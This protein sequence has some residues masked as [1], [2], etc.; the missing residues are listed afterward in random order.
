M[1]ALLSSLGYPITTLARESYDP[2]FQELVYERLRT[3]RNVESIHRGSA[4]APFAIV[5]AL[6]RGRVLGFLV[7]LPGRTAKLEPVRWLG[8]PSRMAR[9]PARLALRTGAPI[10]VGTPAPTASGA[11]SIRVARLPTAD[12]SAGDEG[13]A[14]LSQR[15]ADALSERILALPVHWPWMHPSF[16]NPRF[17]A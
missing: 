12:L 9:G 13:E 2:R 10:V 3:A 15:I 1:A 17:R 5:R 7:D 6:R 4:A 11:L 8:K 14:A 16:A